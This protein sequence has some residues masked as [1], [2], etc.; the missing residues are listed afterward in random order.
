MR[1]KRII[2]SIPADIPIIKPISK[3]Y[4]FV[5]PVKAGIQSNM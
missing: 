4:D 1:G 3:N 2:S 5:I